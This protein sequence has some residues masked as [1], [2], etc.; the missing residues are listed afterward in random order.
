MR[1]ADILYPIVTILKIFACSRLAATF[2]LH[3]QETPETWQLSVYY[4]FILENPLIY[5]V[6]CGVKTP[7]T[8]RYPGVCC[9]RAIG[10]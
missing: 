8:S 3:T 7:F 4:D 2:V 6:C 10:V 5:T 9:G 1:P